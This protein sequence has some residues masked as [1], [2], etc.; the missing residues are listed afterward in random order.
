VDPEV[1][2]SGEETTGSV[3][4]S[5]VLPVSVPPSDEPTVPP[6]SVVVA[7]PESEVEVGAGSEAGA[8]S[9]GGG[10]EAAAPPSPI[11]AWWVATLPMALP[12][13]EAWTGV[14]AWVPGS[15]GW[16]ESPETEFGPGSAVPAPDSEPPAI[17]DFLSAWDLPQA[18]RDP[19][20]H[21]PWS[22]LFAAFDPDAS[23]NADAFQKAASFDR[24]EAYACCDR[25]INK[26]NDA[27]PS[28]TRRTVRRHA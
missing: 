10:P 28:N 20:V 16:V 22:D 5:P 8:E 27:I 13:V 11:D 1:V 26:K 14:E 6:S 24:P 12:S 19:C 18:W 25:N 7:V 23:A 17:S 2:T 15:A 4:V 9:L 3:T 21:L